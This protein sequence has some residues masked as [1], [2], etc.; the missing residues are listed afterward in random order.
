MM[1]RP[2]YLQLPEDPYENSGRFLLWI[3]TVLM[4]AVAFAYVPVILALT[5]ILLTGLLLGGLRAEPIPE[6]RPYDW[7]VD[8]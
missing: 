3:A 5:L 7:E 6:R 8:E 4:I 2:L 1:R